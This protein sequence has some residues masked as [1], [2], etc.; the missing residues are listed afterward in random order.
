MQFLLGYR[1]LV[2]MSVGRGTSSAGAWP[3][4]SFARERLAGGGG[5]TLRRRRQVKITKPAFACHMPVSCSSSSR[6]SSAIQLSRSGSRIAI[7]RSRLWRLPAAWSYRCNRNHLGVLGRRAG[8]VA[9]L[10]RDRLTGS[11]LLRVSRTS[12]CKVISGRLLKRTGTTED[13]A[14][15]EV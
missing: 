6:P 14:P 15:T 12:W 11:T 3:Q 2:S 8:A 13:P 4:A 7:S 9:L 5:R 1:F 10:L